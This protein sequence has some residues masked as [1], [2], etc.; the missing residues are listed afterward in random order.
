[1]DSENDDGNI[2]YKL[3][4]SDYKVS[5][6]T[7]QMR[8]RVNEGNGEARYFIGVE[9]DGSV[10]GIPKADY[11]IT[12]KN[13]KIMAKNNNYALTLLSCKNI[14]NDRNVYEFIV[15]EINPVQY[16]DVKVTVCGSV[17]TGKSTL[18]GVLTTGKYDDG[19]G[20]ARLSIFN[21]K[22]EIDSGRT[23]S[24]AQHIMGF[25]AWGGEITGSWPEIV[26]KSNKIIS[27]YD[28]AGHKK[29]LKTTIN[30][31]TT[32]FPDLAIIM[33]GANMGVTVLT[34]EHLFLCISL[35]I[36]I[37][38]LVSKVDICK[39]RQN[40]LK[41]TLS[42]IKRILKFPQVRKVPY[43]ISS[44]EDV[45]TAATNLKNNSVVPIFKISNVTGLG[46]ENLKTFLSLIPVKKKQQNTEV[47]LLVDTIF[48]IKGI[49]VVLGGHLLSGE[50][51]IND[52]LKLGPINKKGEFENI[53]VKS[54]HVKKVPVLSVIADKYVCLA[55]K[56]KPEIKNLLRHGQVILNKDN[57]IKGSYEFTAEVNI[58]KTHSTSIKIGYEPVI[59]TR[60]IR[61]T[62]KIIKIEGKKCARKINN[63]QILRT[64]DSARIKFR[65]KFRPE[66]IKEGYNLLFCE[67]RVKAVGKIIST[68]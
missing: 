68:L 12:H 50:V 54:I 2:E 52:I 65:F 22:H 66:Y 33:V 48:N 8:F 43:I 58:I 32:S 3:K 49:G 27:F 21:H 59:H 14:E 4:I 63:D 44:E 11:D 26:R 29:Y 55:V 53:T 28:L 10:P 18:I 37:I 19:R 9:D 20:K 5:D 64:G 42:K 40:I 7:T 16:S 31:L 24:I 45:I 57:N 25:N 35:K 47:E 1:M 17:D 60:N 41:E 30:G 38:I 15:R 51:K 46:I 34:R 36:P 61:Q 67:G 56:I 23:S 13:L 62:C 39:N 6:A